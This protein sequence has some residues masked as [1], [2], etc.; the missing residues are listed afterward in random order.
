M[1]ATVEPSLSL[2]TGQD[3][4]RSISGYGAI[5]ATV[6]RWMHRRCFRALFARMD[7]KRASI[8]MPRWH[9]CS[10]ES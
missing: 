5:A 1:A 2:A 9:C 3:P 8:E 6:Q 10:G 7:V 4:N